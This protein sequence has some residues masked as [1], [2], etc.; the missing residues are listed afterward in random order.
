MVKEEKYIRYVRNGS[1]RGVFQYK[2]TNLTHIFLNFVEYAKGGIDEVRYIHHT[3]SPNS[4][5]RPFNIPAGETIC[6]VLHLLLTT[7]PSTKSLANKS[8]CL[9]HCYAERFISFSMYVISKLV[10]CVNDTRYIRL[11]K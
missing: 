3:P 8:K 7:I 6:Y 11:V 10:R 2:R 5:C 1:R 9:H 4:L